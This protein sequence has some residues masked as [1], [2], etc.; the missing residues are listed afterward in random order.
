MADTSNKASAS[1]RRFPKLSRDIILKD[2]DAPASTTV[3]E[4]DTRVA[5]AEMK[6]GRTFRMIGEL[7]TGKESYLM[8]TEK[9]PEAVSAGTNVYKFADKW[10]TEDSAAVENEDAK[11]VLPGLSFP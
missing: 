2:K 5:G 1:E 4:M 8:K 6:P 10:L 7:P 11:L 9:V 3:D